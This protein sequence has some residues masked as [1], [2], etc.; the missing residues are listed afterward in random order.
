MALNKKSLFRM[1]IEAL[2]AAEER[3]EREIVSWAAAEENYIEQVLYNANAYTT[4]VKKSYGYPNTINSD[5]ANAA[6]DAYISANNSA[7]SKRDYAK[8]CLSA[9]KSFYDA[10]SDRELSTTLASI[11]GYADSP[12]NTKYCDKCGCAQL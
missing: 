2:D 3:Y 1:A 10:V 5:D 9:A 12:C 7:L 11:Y 6:L 8:D 4:A